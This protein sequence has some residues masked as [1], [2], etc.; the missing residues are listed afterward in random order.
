MSRAVSNLAKLDYTDLY[1]YMASTGTAMFFLAYVA[2]FGYI[3]AAYTFKGE[4]SSIH[5]A[6]LGAPLVLGPILVYIAVQ[7]VGSM[8]GWL[9]RQHISDSKHKYERKILEQQKQAFENRVDPDLPAD[10]DIQEW[11]GS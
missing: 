4:T 8:D 7:G 11:G 2:L 10:I 9:E 3:T 1:R 6:F 5:I